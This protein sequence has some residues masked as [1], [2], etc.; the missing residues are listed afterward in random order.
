MA[1][2]TLQAIRDKVRKLTRSPSVN[3][4]TDATLDE[5]VNTFI[6]YD[7]PETLR[8]FS[9]HRSVVFYLEPNIDTY[10][11]DAVLNNIN[12][13]TTFNPPLYIGGF[14]AHY[15]QSEEEFYNIYPFNNSIKNTSLTGDGVAVAFSGTLPS[16]PV[17]RGEVT[18]TSK[19]SNND[20]LVLSDSSSDG[21]LSGDG[22]GT[23]DYITGAFTLNFN[24][25][26]ASA[27]PIVSQV[28]P[29]ASS[30]PTS[31][32][33][34]EDKFVFRPVPDQVYKVQLEAFVTP[35]ELLSASSEPE[36]QEWW[37]YIA[38]GAAKKV[39]ED[40]MDLETVQ[41]ITPEFKRQERMILRR[42]IVQQTNQRTSTIYSNMT[43]LG[44]G[45]ADSASGG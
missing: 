26:P 6:S 18:F 30:R 39:L 12:A 3:Q 5:Y 32:L 45:L 19:D 28:V 23:I 21:L 31:M 43:N 11:V 24:A 22:T 29:Y 2:A 37:Q 38:Y 27:E 41:M 35:T 10:T 40:R 16:I 34:F 13:Y 17:L 7:F 36:L 8:L 1:V 44:A 42:T 15:S 9:L 4:L 20:G 25:A 14:K 33:F